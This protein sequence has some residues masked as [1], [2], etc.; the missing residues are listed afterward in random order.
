MVLS[1]TPVNQVAYRLLVWLPA[2]FNEE[3]RLAGFDGRCLFLSGSGIIL[4][5]F[6]IFHSAVR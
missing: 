2:I 1:F 4:L 6:L 3:P 5:L